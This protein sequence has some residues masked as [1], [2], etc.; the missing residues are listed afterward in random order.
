MSVDRLSNML[1]ALKNASMAKKPVIEI[2]HSNECES[3]VKILKE[4]GFLSEVKVFKPKG[5]PYK[6]MNIELSH[7]GDEY[8]LSQA[9]RV[10]KPGR[11]VYLSSAKLRAVAG[12]RGVCIVSTNR[13][14]LDSVEAKKKKL[15]G[16]ILCEV[17]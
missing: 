3:V 5:K 17:R 4:K 11:R 13:G 1:S 16:E 6:M 12:G 7:Q 9:N 14:I 10:S 8:N 2:L 15:G